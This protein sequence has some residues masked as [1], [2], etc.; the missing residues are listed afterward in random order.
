MNILQNL[1]FT[2]KQT[3]EKSDKVYKMCIVI[4]D[5]NKAFQDAVSEV[6]SY[7]IDEH[8]AKFKCRLSLKQYMVNKAIK[9][10]FK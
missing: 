8:M 10:V 9:W 1:H 6:E 2:D 3:A 4:N 7:S 5:L